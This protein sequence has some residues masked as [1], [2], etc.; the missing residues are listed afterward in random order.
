MEKITNEEVLRRMGTNRQ[1]NSE[2]KTRKFQYLGH[3]VRH[4]TSQL[5]LIEGN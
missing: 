4:N 2:F 5:Q 1:I 3:L